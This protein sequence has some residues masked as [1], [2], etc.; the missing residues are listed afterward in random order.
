MVDALVIESTQ[1]A[2]EF[3]AKRMLFQCRMADL[4][5]LRDHDGHLPVWQCQGDELPV[6]AQEQPALLPDKG[7]PH[8]VAAM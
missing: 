1:H 6:N 2:A 3:T 5:L 7:G 4:R 8:T